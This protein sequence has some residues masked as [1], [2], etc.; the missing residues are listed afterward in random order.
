MKVRKLFFPFFLKTL[1]QFFDT[2]VAAP[3]YRFNELSGFTKMFGL[4][5]AVLKDFIQIMRLEMIPELS[6]GF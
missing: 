2:R 4:P 6:E 3:P 1:E 5:P